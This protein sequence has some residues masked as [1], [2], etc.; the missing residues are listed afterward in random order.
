MKRGASAP[1]FYACVISFGVNFDRIQL[2]AYQSL[3]IR[4][5]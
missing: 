4:E 1:F 3:L 5:H 2:V